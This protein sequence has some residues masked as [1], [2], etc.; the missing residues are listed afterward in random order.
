MQAA[1]HTIVVS[2]DLSCPWARVAV[3]RLHQ[4][5]RKLGL[6]QTVAFDHRAFPLEL[7]NR[8]PT[9]KGLV[10]A[11]VPVLGAH[12]PDA[13][14]QRWQ[15]PES[16]YPVTTLLALEAVQAAKEQ[17]LTASE[18]L[19]VGLRSA[20]FAQ[21]RCISLLHVILEVAAE[22]GGVDETALADAL[23]Q[24]HAR[25]LVMQ[26]FRTAK[27]EGFA[28]SPHVFLPDGSHVFNPGIKAHWV[29]ARDTGFPAIHGDD[30]A[31]YDELLARAA[32]A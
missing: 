31:I 2:S 26:Q 30:P 4:S 14:W 21:S 9:P 25:R 6:E 5:R 16:A 18:Q 10:D 7:E 17:S 15:A 28:G 27:Q 29:G 8:E 3:Y 1:H 22:C 23:D 19:D 11:E 32:G 20:F 13:G 24:G 12:E